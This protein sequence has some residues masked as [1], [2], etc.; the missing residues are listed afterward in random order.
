M[1]ERSTSTNALIGAVVTVLASF[2][3]FSPVV[4]GAVAGYLEGRNGARVG[5]ISGAMAAVP[6]VLLGLLFAFFIPIG[7]GMGM[8]LSPSIAMVVFV[9]FALVMVLAYTVGLSAVGGLLGVYLAAQRGR[10]P[11]G[12]TAGGDEPAEAEPTAG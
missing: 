2:V 1:S 5:A 11:E 8:G 4:G 6:L 12:P 10:D 9:L 7:M 3:P